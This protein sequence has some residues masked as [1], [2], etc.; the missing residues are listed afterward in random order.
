M[1]IGHTYLNCP[2]NVVM[3][4]DTKKTVWTRVKEALTE[5]K[6]PATQAQAALLAGV[7]QPSVSDWNKLGGY[8]EMANAVQLATKLGYCVEWILTGRGPRR[9]PDASIS[10]DPFFQQLVDVWPKL[11]VDSRREVL[12]MAKFKM[13]DQ[14]HAD[15]TVHLVTQAE[16]LRAGKPGR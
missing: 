14:D 9:V 2:H 13:V 6:L 3:S 4:E 12:G 11:A 10:S 8:P 7:K 15:D 5:R 16:Q 1:S